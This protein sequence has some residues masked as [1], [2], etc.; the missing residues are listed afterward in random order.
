[1]YKYFEHVIRLEKKP[2]IIEIIFNK[3]DKVIYY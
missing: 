3:Y 2:T 1:M